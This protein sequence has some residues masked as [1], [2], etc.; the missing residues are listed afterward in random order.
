M[1]KYYSYAICVECDH[2]TF[3][4]KGSDITEVPVRCEVCGNDNLE[5]ITDDDVV[6][7]EPD[8]YESGH[9]WYSFP[10][11]TGTLNYIKNK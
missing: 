1:K 5:Y 11:T 8:E 7:E 2:M 4:P 6:V 9:K 10:Y 3:Y